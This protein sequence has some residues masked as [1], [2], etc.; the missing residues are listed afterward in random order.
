VKDLKSCKYHK[1]TQEGRGCNASLGTQTKLNRDLSATKIIT[2]ENAS[3]AE[4]KAINDVKA[5][6]SRQNKRY[7]C[8]IR[9]IEELNSLS[10]TVTKI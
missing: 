1:R 4:K 6:G 10:V 8:K 3:Y 7:K 9:T 2:D 5:E